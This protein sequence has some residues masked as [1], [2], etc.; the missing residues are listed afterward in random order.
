MLPVGDA[1]PCQGRFQDG[2]IELTDDGIHEGQ[3]PS[4]RSDNRM[5]RRQIT[6]GRSS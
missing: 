2:D 5:R 4:F 3:E 6:T 1:N